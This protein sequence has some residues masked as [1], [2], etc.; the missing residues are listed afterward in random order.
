MNEFKPLGDVIAVGYDTPASLRQTQA[1]S[2]ASFTLLSDMDL[3]VTR[4]YNMQLR[5]GW[6]VIQGV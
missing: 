1:G 5:E 2:R 4:L 3:E 6:P